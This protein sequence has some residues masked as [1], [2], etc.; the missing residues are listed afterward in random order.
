MWY[1]VFGDIQRLDHLKFGKLICNIPVGCRNT[2][3]TLD[4][5]V[6][7]AEKWTTDAT[8]DV[9]E[10]ARISNVIRYSLPNL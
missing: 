9:K 1:E 6:S 3:G 10:S 5:S 7:S 8:V 4:T 2:A